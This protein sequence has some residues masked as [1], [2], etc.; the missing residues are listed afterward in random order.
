MELQTRVFEKMGRE[1]YIKLPKAGTN[2]RGVEFAKEALLTLVENEESKRIIIN[3]QRKKI[4]F[5][6]YRRWVDLWG[7]D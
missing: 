1:N 6:P 5:N 2:P 3:W 7:E 4:D